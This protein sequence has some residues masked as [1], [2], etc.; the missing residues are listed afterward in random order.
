[1]PLAALLLVLPLAAR[2]GDQLTLEAGTANV[3]W[4]I[5]SAYF[6]S[7]FSQTTV[8]GKTY[9]EWLASRGDDFVRDWPED[10]RKVDDYFINRFNRKTKKK[11]GLHLQNDNP[12]DAYHFVVHPLE[13]DMGSVGGGVVATVFLGAFAKKA[14]G[15]VIKTGYVDVTEAATGK[16]VCRLSIKDVRGDNSISVTNML[17]MLFEDL[18]NEIIGFSERFGDQRKPEIMADGA[19]AAPAAV[20]APA[21]QPAQAAP[22]AAQ[23][24]PVAA[25][26][27]PLS[28]KTAAAP[29]TPVPIE[30]QVI[31]KL[32]SGASI[33]GTMVRFDPLEEIVMLVG[34]NE[35]TIPMTKVES[36]EMLNSPATPQPAARPA[37]AAQ[38]PARTLS[39]TQVSLGSRKLLV[40][41]TAT[42][43]ER[44]AIE[45]GG[46]EI[47]MVLV[48]G[49]R[50]NMGF[51]GSNSRSMKSEPVHEVE[52][53]SFYMSEG[54]LTCKQVRAFTSDYKNSGDEPALIPNWKA[55]NAL[56]E[57]I[58]QATGRKFR[59]PTEAE[60][61]YAACSNEQN[62]IFHDIASRD[63][64]AMDWCW[65]YH[66]EF[67]RTGGVVTD[68]TGPV[69]G[70]DH[71]VRAFN[72]PKGKFDRSNKVS[73]GKTELG[74]VR[75]T[76]KAA[77]LVN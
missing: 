41:E 6:E 17:M 68:P 42:Y 55:A 8:E 14:G 47:V 73:F 63:K 13:M 3:F 58:A 2:D 31:V 4:T 76:I 64:A 20:P 61:E 67:Q 16:I 57:A 72:A 35:T 18:R 43:P 51:D 33:Q 25:K 21:A 39:N 53:T 19:L 44:L 9:D 49:G 48:K 26:P 15:C 11:S 56:A 34:G 22:V 7:D 5:P 27:A 32:K 65:D 30:Q 28:V 62:D 46:E 37:V 12:S 38:Q 69:R 54:A 70:D 23:A 40:T 75:L 36:V 24:A 74:Y 60:W 77:D 50:M 52:V 59:L 45:A 10:K 29:S 66:D 71:V 1:M